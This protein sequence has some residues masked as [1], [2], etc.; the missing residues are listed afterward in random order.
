MTSLNTP[1]VKLLKFLSNFLIGG[2]ERQFVHVA[3]GLDRSRFDVEIGCL[4]R[5]G[6]LLDSLEHGMPVHEYPV[7]GSFY[8]GRSILAQLKLARQVRRSRFD[9]VHAYGWNTNVFAIP[10]SRLACRPC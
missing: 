7:K 6:P 8:N 4:L 10:A 3:N 2:T 1:R 9:I 5:K